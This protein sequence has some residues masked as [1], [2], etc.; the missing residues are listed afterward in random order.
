MAFWADFFSGES[1][2]DSPSFPRAKKESSILA[3]STP[4]KSTLV[5]VA[6]TYRWLTRLNGT[7]L[8]LY[9]P[10]V[11]EKKKGKTN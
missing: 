7:P 3:T 4:A 1:S 6:M 9:G 10:I 8:T 5:E 2:L 11:D